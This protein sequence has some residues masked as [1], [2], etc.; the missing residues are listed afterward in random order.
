MMLPKSTRL[1]FLDALPIL[2]LLE[3]HADYYPALSVLLDT[4][5]TR[6]IQMIASP[7]TLMD[8]ARVAFRMDNP[9]LAQQ[10]HE[11]FTRSAHL[12]LRD[13]DASVVMEAALL[14]EKYAFSV[15]ESIQLA[16][17]NVCGADLLLTGNTR[18]RDWCQA[19]VLTL[20]DLLAS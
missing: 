14:R 2:R 17:A 15:S 6:R 7:M 4:V 8:A 12:S 20:D 9:V 18:W 16:T 3:F 11:F 5:Y 19:E 1:L 10:Y 13:I